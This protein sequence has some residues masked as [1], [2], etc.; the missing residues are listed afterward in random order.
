MWQIMLDWVLWILNPFK[1]LLR[2][3]RTE[4]SL[5][6]QEELV[7]MVAGYGLTLSYSSESSVETEL[8]RESTADVLTIAV[9]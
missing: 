4:N 1:H 8:Q 3:K 2:S 5:V 6:I 7:G 9:S